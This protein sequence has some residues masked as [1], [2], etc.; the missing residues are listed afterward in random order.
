MGAPPSVLLAFVI[1]VCVADK[2][3]SSAQRTLA[4]WQP[5]LRRAQPSS[6]PLCRTPAPPTTEIAAQSVEPVVV[7]GQ[8]IVPFLSAH[9]H[10]ACRSCLLCRRASPPTSRVHARPHV[11]ADAPPTHVPPTD[12]YTNPRTPTKHGHAR[13]G[14][15]FWS[16]VKL[17]LPN[18]SRPTPSHPALSSQM[19][20]GNRH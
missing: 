3:Q 10:V 2:E 5:D 15:C 7:E 12:A 19:L 4:A 6:N 11:C 16:V 8:R 13:H 9:S 17:L 18:P 1:G 20:S 14:P